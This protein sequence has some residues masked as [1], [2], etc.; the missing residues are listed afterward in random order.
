MVAHA[1]PRLLTRA[2]YARMAE[3]G[4]FADERV[5]LIHGTVVRMAP[6]GTGH[7]DVVDV[8]LELF[9][10]RLVGRATV[11]IQA[12]FLAHDESE[13]EPD[14]AIVPRRR[15]TDRHP[16]EAFLVIEVADS[17]LTYDRHTKAPL[18]AASGVPEY[19]I[20][21]VVGRAIE[22]YRQGSG[23][24]YAV[25]ERVTAGSVRPE[26]FPDVELRLAELFP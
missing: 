12:P 5:E 14:L 16:H 13:P 17:S 22:V 19:W 7:C 2:E 9:V 18:Y 15:Y 10:S 6:I 21:D 20:V 3:L 23:D 1:T 4:F 26:A 24:R 25:H 8:C 11:R